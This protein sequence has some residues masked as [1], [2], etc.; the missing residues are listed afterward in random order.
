MRRITRHGVTLLSD[1]T[2]H[3]VTEDGRWQVSHVP[4]YFECENPHP[5]KDGYCP[6]WQQHDHNN[7]WGVLDAVDCIIGD[8]VRTFDEA[9]RELAVRT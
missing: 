8:I 6:G 2:G 9:I 1:R 3:Y 4:G 7:W 5:T